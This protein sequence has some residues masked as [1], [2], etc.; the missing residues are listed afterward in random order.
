MT[1]I[2]FDRL[3]DTSGLKCPLPV[4]RARKLIKTMSPG[5]HLKIICT[6]PLADIDIPHMAATDGHQLLDKG[7]DGDQRWYALKI[8]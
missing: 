5:T 3:L 6:D 4:I 8:A 2:S 1:E 7:R